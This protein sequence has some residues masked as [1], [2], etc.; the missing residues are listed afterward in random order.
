V[1][2]VRERLDRKNREKVLRKPRFERRS[3]LSCVIPCVNRGIGYMFGPILNRTLASYDSLYVNTE[4][5]EHC[6]SSVLDFLELK[7]LECLGI[8]EKPSGSKE[9]PG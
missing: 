3:E 5:R 1:K 9:A 8:L 2:E 7:F 4:H 6:K